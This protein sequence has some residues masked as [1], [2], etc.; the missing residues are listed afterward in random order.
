[1]GSGP[2]STWIPSPA[3]R[4]IS[5]SGRSPGNPVARGTAWDR[6]G[7]ADRDPAVEEPADRGRSLPRRL[8][9]GTGRSLAGR[10]PA[11]KRLVDRC[12]VGTDRVGRGRAPERTDLRFADADLNP[13]GTRSPPEPEG[14]CSQSRSRRCSRTGRLSA[15]LWACRLPAAPS[16]RSPRW[17]RT[18]VRRD[19]SP[20]SRHHREPRELPGPLVHPRPRHRGPFRN[21]SPARARRPT[22]RGSFLLSPQRIFRRST[23]QKAR[24]SLG[25]QQPGPRR[26][27]PS[28]PRRRSVSSRRIRRAYPV[29]KCSCPTAAQCSSNR[30]NQ[31]CRSSMCSSQLILGC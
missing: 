13:E 11:G 7:Q 14:R 10:L 6:I 20:R 19:P 24:D 29:L 25:P 8:P 2:F 15:W 1:M 21:S 17:N 23:R 27:D 26:S 22:Q 3:P 18:R 16:E 9:V 30:N 4:R 12:L 5:T 28:D 31:L